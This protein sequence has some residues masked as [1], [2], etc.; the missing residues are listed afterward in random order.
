MQSFRRVLSE[1]VP[2]DTPALSSFTLWQ[3]RR[4]FLQRGMWGKA[5]PLLS[6]HPHP[7]LCHPVFQGASIRRVNVIGQAQM[8]KLLPLKMQCGLE[9]LGGGRMWSFPW[10]AERGLPSPC[11]PGPSLPTEM[12]SIDLFSV[13]DARC[14]SGSPA[15]SHFS[16]RPHWFL[17]WLLLQYSH[18]FLY[19]SWNNRLGGP[20]FSPELR[21]LFP[22]TCWIHPTRYL[23]GSS[24]VTYP[25]LNSFSFFPPDL[26]LFC[27]Q[28]QLW[29]HHSNRTP[30]CSGLPTTHLLCLVN[31]HILI[32]L[33]VKCL[34]NLFT[35]LCHLCANF[36]LSPLSAGPV[37]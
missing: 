4:H 34:L 11:L 25:R 27:F 37:G 36:V 1:G 6:G 10:Y 23:S 9:H 30:I 33:P 7:S 15:L 35:F 5:G 16:L 14:L 32:I 17:G 22:G 12:S 31:P 2:A 28:S 21:L 20:A 3:G 29:P 13:P 24:T 26:F 19:S 18:S 8:R